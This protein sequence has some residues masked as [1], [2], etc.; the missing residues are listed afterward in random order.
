MPGS[1]Q[2][3]PKRAACWSPAMPLMGAPEA[4][5]RC[6][7]QRRTPGRIAHRRA[8]PREGPPA[9]TPKRSHSSSD[10][11]RTTMSKSRVREALVASVANTPPSAP[12]V[13]FHSTQEST[14][15]RAET[16]VRSRQPALVAAATASWW[17]RSRGRGPGR[18][19]PGPA[20]GGRPRSSA[21][22]RPR[23][24]GPARR[25]PGA[26]GSPVRRSQATTVSRWLVMP[27]AR[28]TRLP[29][30]QPSGH[31]GQG[32]P[33]RVPDLVG[34]VL[35]PARPGEVLGELAVGHVDDPSP[36]VHHQ[37]PHPGG[38]GVDG[39]G[40]G[41]AGGHRRDCSDAPTAPRLCRHP[42]LRRLGS[43]LPRAPGAGRP[44]TGDLP[45]TPGYPAPVRNACGSNLL[46]TFANGLPAG[47]LAAPRA[48]FPENS[49]TGV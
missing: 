3:W 22:R 9:G 37:R 48:R 11:R 17:P 19:A 10:H 4:G 28:A 30:G 13:R 14:V 25:W 45:L 6:P 49:L 8:A 47:I 23:C 41:R 43:R 39:D 38:P 24:G 27:M 15:P 26:R 20:G 32:R 44:A 2:A 31:L 40:D 18:S 21:R 7:E 35:D 46:R 36:L 16:A 29:V 33:H 1:K 34:V 12:P 5:S 42:R